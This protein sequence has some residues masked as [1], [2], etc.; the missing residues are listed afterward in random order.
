MALATSD[1]KSE[2]TP[3]KPTS[4]IGTQGA[5]VTTLL[6]PAEPVLLPDID[7]VL[8]VRLYPGAKDAADLRAQ[9][10]AAGKAAHDAAVKEPEA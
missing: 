7:P 3:Q 6:P 2:P 9:A 4:G 1:H 5:P 10:M 8:L